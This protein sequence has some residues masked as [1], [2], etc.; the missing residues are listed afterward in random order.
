MP[1]FRSAFLCIIIVGVAVGTEFCHAES[2][3]VS[4]P[5]LWVVTIVDGGKYNFSR[6]II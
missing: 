2:E 1:I 3:V 6:C 4:D 5:S